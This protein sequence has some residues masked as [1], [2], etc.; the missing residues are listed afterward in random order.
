MSL[1]RMSL[2]C[3]GGDILKKILI[4]MNQIKRCEQYSTTSYNTA[5]ICQ[6]CLKPKCIHCSTGIWKVTEFKKC[7]SSLV[8][9]TWGLN[10]H[11]TYRPRLLK[12]FVHRY[13]LDTYT[14]A[15]IPKTCHILSAKLNLL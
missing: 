13:L 5:I 15:C 10:L 3:S 14:F 12:L 4:V 9:T 6:P 11:V 7:I 2:K 1:K 8:Q